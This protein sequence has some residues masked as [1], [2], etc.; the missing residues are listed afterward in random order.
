M[1][2]A[3]IYVGEIGQRTMR[4]KDVA[5]YIRRSDSV[6]IVVGAGASISSGIPSAAKLV[7][8]V[9]QE[10]P[11][12]L[13][14]FSAKDSSD[15]GRVMGALSPGDRKALIQ[16]LLENS[17]VNWGHIALAC[18]IKKADVKRV[19]TFNFDLLLERSASLLGMHLPVYDFGV[20]PTKDIAGLASPAIFHLHGQSYGLR[21]MNSESETETHKELLRPLL[22][23]SVRNHTTIVIGYSG[24]ADPAFA[25]MTDE[26]NSNMNLLWLGYSPEPAQNLSQLLSKDY[27]HYI[28][29]CDFDR[30]MIEIAEELGCWPPEIVKNPPMHVLAELTEVVEYPV[31]REKQIDVLTSARRRLEQIAAVWDEQK[32]DESLVQDAF[33]SR[34]PLSVGE[35][36]KNVTKS[37]LESRIWLEVRFGDDLAE[38]ADN[39]DD[40]GERQELLS[41]AAKHYKKALSYRSDIPEVLNNW[42]LMLAEEARRLTGKE[43]ARYFHLAYKKYAKS[44]E[45]APNNRRTLENWGVALMDESDQLEGANR[46]QHLADA[47]EKLSKG[48]EI[49]GLP[50]YNLACVFALHG[51]L[52]KALDELMD[53]VKKGV[54]PSRKMIEGDEDLAGLRTNSRFGE[55]L[56]H[57]DGQAE[58]NT[59]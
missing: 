53:C 24:S 58:Q 49:S 10:F 14:D 59:A 5:G 16:P 39:T 56:D 13:S 40:K 48:R 2:R 27:A 18:I 25:V 21:L 44:I 55:L 54:A 38:R 22:A 28:G 1:W 4:I 43:A 50:S 7:D 29:S 41:E 36:G 47:A 45:L 15:Y 42:G 3:L 33:L 31:H 32:D 8:L 34:K 57:L 17:K 26:F 11:H 12:C 6:S 46:M 20:A 35:P 9:A 37:E 19:L 23:D 30:T 52:E 51:Q